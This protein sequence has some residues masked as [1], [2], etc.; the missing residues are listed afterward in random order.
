MRGIHAF[1]GPWSETT[2]KEFGGLS[3]WSGEHCRVGSS[4]IKAKEEGAATPV[5]DHRLQ[6]SARLPASISLRIT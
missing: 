1:R 5:D 4:R 3:H 2:S 6:A